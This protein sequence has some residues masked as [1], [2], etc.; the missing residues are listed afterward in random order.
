METEVKPVTENPNFRAELLARLGLP[1]NAGPGHIEA[2][3]RSSVAMLDRLPADQQ[4]WASGQRAELDAI[5]SLL[6][7]ASAAA[8][9]TAPTRSGVAAGATS[10]DP[11]PATEVG[12]PTVATSRRRVVV[13]M[14]SG[15]AVVAVAAVGFSFLHS[16]DAVPGITGT[17]TNTA[18]AS[19]AASL[20]MGQVA[21]LMQKIA[22]NPK[23]TASLM[24]LSG[25]YFDSGDYATSSHFSQEVLKLAPKNDTAWVALG[26]AQFNLGKNADAKV[27]WDKAIAINPG[28]ANAFYDLG[29]Y[30]LSG[31]KPDVAMVRTEW[32]KVVAI[33]PTSALAKN[34][35][36]HLASLSS[37]S[38]S[39][40][41]AGK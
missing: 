19:P 9:P 28:N 35:Q 29:F 39:A 34:V 22:A 40:T 6:M 2:A 25:M 3:Y 10:Q 14:V 1:A 13:A 17:P 7:E 20:N 31:A 41:A 11:A 27:S 37:P 5:R 30:Y 12:T 21:A 16:K 36:T 24:S 18:S 4:G 23:D 38:A 33:D 26:A 32:L 8:S 15:L